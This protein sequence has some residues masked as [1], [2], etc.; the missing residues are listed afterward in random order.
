MK[1]FWIISR[2]VLLV[3]FGLSFVG[4]I[5]LE[6]TLEKKLREEISRT[7]GDMISFEDLSINWLTK[8]PNVA[9]SLNGLTVKSNLNGDERNVYSMEQ[10]VVVAS[11]LE[12][13]DGELELY[14]LEVVKPQIDIVVD[15]SGVSD[16][17]DL[18]DCLNLL[19]VDFDSKMDLETEKLRNIQISNGSLSV[20][21]ETSNSKITARGVNWHLS[22]SN[23]EHTV[24]STSLVITSFSALIGGENIC[25]NLPI[26]IKANV[27]ADFDSDYF[28]IT[29]ETISFYGTEKTLQEWLDLAEYS[30]R[31]LPNL[32]P[33][34]FTLGEST[35]RINMPDMSN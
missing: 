4:N 31:R 24:M 33:C 20:V 32:G 12:L 13:L 5:L 19:T 30:G 26:E 1:K 27:D 7:S 22:G 2:V 3:V 9:V 34:V 28:I 29:P 11:P 14:S 10:A 15:N 18:M 35:Y 6:N 21:D 23:A 8:F 16:F 25:E 17:D